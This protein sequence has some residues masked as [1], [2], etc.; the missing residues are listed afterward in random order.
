MFLCLC[1]VG[2][3]Q[4]LQGLPNAATLLNLLLIG[5]MLEHQVPQGS[6]GSLAHRRVGAPQEGHQ[7]RNPAQLQD[8]AWACSGHIT[9][10][11]H[12]SPRVN[13]EAKQ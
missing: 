9:N 1:G 11:H 5:L 7:Y 2:L 10:L 13:R 4:Q 12:L 8:L 3:L 6:S